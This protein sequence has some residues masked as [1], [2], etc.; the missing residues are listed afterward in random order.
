MKRTLENITLKEA[1]EVYEI[2][3]P[4]A[5]KRH[6][7]KQFVFNE[8]EERQEKRFLL[9][10]EDELW[11]DEKTQPFLVFN[12]AISNVAIVLP[13][14]QQTLEKY[15]RV[16]SYL[17]SNG[18][19]LNWLSE[20]DKLTGYLGEKPLVMPEFINEIEKAINQPQC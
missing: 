7:G 8:C 4:Y 13:S 17:Y 5:A 2:L 3:D 12:W 19:V 1:F 9:L 18:I 14:T 15:C 11:D 10:S 6:F 16:I 20:L